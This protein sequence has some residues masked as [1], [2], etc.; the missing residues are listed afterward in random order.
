[1]IAIHLGNDYANGN[2]HMF[3]S[4]AEIHA[5]TFAAIRAYD[6][7]NVQARLHVTG[8]TYTA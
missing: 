3:S 6:R 4:V 2:A 1:M 5:G 7:R 8:T